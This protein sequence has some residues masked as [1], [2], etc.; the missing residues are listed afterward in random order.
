MG[1]NRVQYYQ[2]DRRPYFRVNLT[3]GGSVID[4]TLASGVQMDLYADPN[5]DVAA[6][7]TGACTIVDA[8]AGLVEYPWGA[9]ELGTPGDFWAIFTIDWGGELE[10]VP[11][12]GPINLVVHARP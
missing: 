3:R 1:V 4:L 9:G 10:G 2:G 6:V 12:M 5:S 8:A 7:V 11:D